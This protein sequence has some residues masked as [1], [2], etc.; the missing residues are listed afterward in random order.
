MLPRLVSNSWAQAICPP[1]LPKVLG[2]QSNRRSEGQFFFFILF[3]VF[4]FFETE[5]CSV[6]QAGVQWPDL[7][8]LQAPP[9]GFRPFSCL[10]L[11]SSWDYR[12]PPPR[13]ASFLYF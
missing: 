13:P 1:Q 6:A 11:P 10:S 9:P 12:R 3:L 4:F 2:L 5:S 7:S 8:S